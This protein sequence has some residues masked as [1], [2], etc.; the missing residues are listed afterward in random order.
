MSQARV[1]SVYDCSSLAE[2]FEGSEGPYQ[3]EGLL[4][5]RGWE[6]DVRRWWGTMGKVSFTDRL[7]ANET[8]DRRLYGSDVDPS[9]V[10]HQV[11][12]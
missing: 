10:S 6:D 4:G 8:G 5:G 11:M 7:F 9:G 3:N 2:H 1:E 12:T